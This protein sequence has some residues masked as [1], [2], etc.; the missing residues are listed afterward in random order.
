VQKKYGLYAISAKELDDAG[1]HLENV[2]SYLN[3]VTSH[4]LAWLGLACLAL[5]WLGLA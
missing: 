2:V 3:P 1:L 4:A 5:A